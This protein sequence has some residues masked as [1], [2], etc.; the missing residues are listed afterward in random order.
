MDEQPGT[1]AP[2]FKYTTEFDANQPFV[3]FDISVFNNSHL[4]NKM[5]LTE[6]RPLATTQS[7]SIHINELVDD[8]DQD[9]DSR[10]SSPDIVQQIAHEDDWSKSAASTTKY[11]N[12]IN[13]L[14]RILHTLINNV[15]SH[16][17]WK[18]NDNLVIDLTNM[19]MVWAHII[20]FHINLSSC[21]YHN[22]QSLCDKVASLYSSSHC[23]Y[24][25]II[26]YVQSSQ[27]N[28]NTLKHTYIA[29]KRIS[30]FFDEL[31]TVIPT[32]RQYVT[33]LLE[34]QSSSDSS[35][36]SYDVDENNQV[37]LEWLYEL[38]KLYIDSEGELPCKPKQMM[39]HFQ[40]THHKLTDQKFHQLTSLIE[41]H[42]GNTT[43]HDITN[44]FHQ[45]L[46]INWS[47]VP[48]GLKSC[49]II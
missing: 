12:S 8:T 40:R 37:G 34:M 21:D 30:Q 45:W 16:S 31:Q 48:D 44:N 47:I 46:Q 28:S 14:L 9:N 25:A 15:D 13:K 22:I 49:F 36:N 35:Y 27:I 4:F 17:R 10:V 18:L 43:L 23:C 39:K 33:Y 38:V 32:F 3:T 19:K 7:F 6:S 24:D 26:R 42:F 29:Y 5:E 11:I 41:H 20:G 1:G 2:H